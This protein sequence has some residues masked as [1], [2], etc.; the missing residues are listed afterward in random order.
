[1]RAEIVQKI[2]AG[3]V[4]AVIRLSDSQR[5]RKVV[6]AIFAGGISAIEITMTIPNAVQVIEDLAKSMGEMIQIGVGSVLDAA[7]A[8]SAIL[9]GAKYVVSPIFKPEIVALAHRYDVP[10]IPGAF[11][12]TEIQ[13]AH[14]YGADI[15]KVFPADIVGMA[16]FKAIKAP[17]PHLRLLPTGGVT[18]TN[19]G[20]WLKAGACAVGV[21]SALLDKKA[22]AAENY[23]Q[24]IENA[25][26]LC[27]SIAE[28]RE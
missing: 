12:P 7:A 2:I 20:D 16:F 25:K 17:L 26:I 10:A 27:R 3:G 21:G 8:Q 9:A 4:I 22:I 28:G 6:E 13:T 11:S 19:A 23:A 5:L 14:E 15:V 1:M 18:L 24:L